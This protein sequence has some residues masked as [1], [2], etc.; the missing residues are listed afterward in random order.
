[1]DKYDK[2]CDKYFKEIDK[3]FMDNQDTDQPNSD[4]A[5]LWLKQLRIDYLD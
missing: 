4:E 5:N 1:M 2:I 3:T